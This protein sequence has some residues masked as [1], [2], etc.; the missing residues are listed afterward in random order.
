MARIAFRIIPNA[1]KTEYAGVYG[2]AVK[3]RLSSPPLEGKANAE[4]LRFLSKSLGVS[5]NEIKIVAGET[6]RNKLLSL[7]NFDLAAIVA[8]FEK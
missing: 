1:K 8:H 6:S 2:D 5:K 4:L 7:E 3:I